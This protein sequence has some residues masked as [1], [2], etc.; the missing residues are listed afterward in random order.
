M[1]FILKPEGA[2]RGIGVS[3]IKNKEDCDI[4]FNDEQINA[5]QDFIIQEYLDVK[6]EYR[7]FVLGK[8]SLGVC[9][10]I[11]EGLVAKNFAQEVNLFT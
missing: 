6:N 3:L 4:Y 8:K 9:E 7:V 11:G 5:F 2:S 1:P 10:K